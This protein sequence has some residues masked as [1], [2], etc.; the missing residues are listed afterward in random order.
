MTGDSPHPVDTLRELAVDRAQGA[1]HAV[2]IRRDCHQ[3]RVVRHQAVREDLESMTP[4]MRVQQAQVRLWIS[5]LEE[6]GLAVIPPLRHMMGDA[7]KQDSAVSWH[8][9]TVTGLRA[10]R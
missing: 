9:Q 10:R 7:W 4:G 2:G 5:L 3:M 1:M 6:D 8:R